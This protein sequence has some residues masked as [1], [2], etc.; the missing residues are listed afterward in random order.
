LQLSGTSEGIHYTC[1]EE[2]EAA[3]GKWF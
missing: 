1:D 2:A 3:A